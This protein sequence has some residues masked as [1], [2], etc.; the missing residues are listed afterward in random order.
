[1]YS[2]KTSCSNQPFD[3]QKSHWAVIL[4][5]FSP[6]IVVQLS[7]ACRWC[8]DKEPSNIST[9]AKPFAFLIEIGLESSEK[10][11][12]IAKAQQEEIDSIAASTGTVS[13]SYA[14]ISPSHAISGK[15]EVSTADIHDACLKAAGALRQAG[16][17]VQ[18]LPNSTASKQFRQASLLGCQ[19]AVVFGDSELADGKVSVKDLTS[20]IQTMIPIAKLVEDIQHR[21]E[22]IG[23]GADLELHL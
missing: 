22:C 20:G 16:I 7:S 9:F 12:S 17:S 2:T 19:V 13:L 14:E 15:A 5:L 6:V 11:G 10:K 23:A 3:Y 1:M 8:R 4:S 18:R 21:K